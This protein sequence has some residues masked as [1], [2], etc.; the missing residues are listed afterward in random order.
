MDAFAM[1]RS[2]AAV[3]ELDE[4]VGAF[5]HIE[6][7][8][9][10]L[11]FFASGGEELVADLF[12]G[13]GLSQAIRR[14]SEQRPPE[15]CP[16]LPLAACIVRRGR[17]ELVTDRHKASFEVGEWKASWRAAEYAAAVEQVRAAIARGDVYQVNLVQHLSAPFHGDPRALAL[18]EEILTEGR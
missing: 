1:G 9:R 2:T 6:E 16:A 11:G 3:L 12:L 7:W 8:L 15:P 5:E 17:E 18:F 13:Y 4:P 10:G 14:R